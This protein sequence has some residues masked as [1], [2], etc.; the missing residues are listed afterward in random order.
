M[1]KHVKYGGLSLIVLIALG[2]VFF[3][4]STNVPN[5]NGASNVVVLYPGQV[6]RFTHPNSGM[7]T[8]FMFYGGME[9]VPL[10]N[11]ETAYHEQYYVVFLMNGGSSKVIVYEGGFIYAGCLYRITELNQ[12]RLVLEKQ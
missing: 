10:Y 7:L 8:S 3:F 4:T 6:L 5:V 9:A 2:A 11:Q 1:K 12:H